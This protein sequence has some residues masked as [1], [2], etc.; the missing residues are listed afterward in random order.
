[1]E[2]L[3]S[4]SEATLLCSHEHNRY[5]RCIVPQFKDPLQ[6]EMGSGGSHQ[7]EGTRCMEQKGIQDVKPSWKYFHSWAC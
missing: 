5:R 2:L 3:R 7:R 1:M 4:S 6:Q